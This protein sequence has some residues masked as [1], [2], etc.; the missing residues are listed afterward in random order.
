MLNFTTV[1]KQLNSDKFNLIPLEKNRTIHILFSF[2][3][4]RA[5]LFENTHVYL[6]KICSIRP[7]TAN[8]A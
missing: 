3:F 5:Q 2:Y 6:R 7:V 8:A 4:Y 1:S